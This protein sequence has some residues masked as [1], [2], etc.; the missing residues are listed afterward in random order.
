MIDRSHQYCQYGSGE[1][2]ES[3]T[4]TTKQK[5]MFVT[6][7]EGIFRRRYVYEILSAQDLSPPVTYIWIWLVWFMVLNATFNSISVILWQSCFLVEETGVPGE[8]H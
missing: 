6:M 5:G 8:N 1:D 4:E 2:D 3:L 7:Y